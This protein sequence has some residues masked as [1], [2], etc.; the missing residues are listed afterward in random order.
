MSISISGTQSTYTIRKTSGETFTSS[1]TMYLKAG[2]YEEYGADHATKPVTGGVTKTITFTEDFEQY[3]IYTYPKLIYARYISEGGYW[4]WV[5]PIKIIPELPQSNETDY[6]TDRY[7]TTT[8][9]SYQETRLRLQVSIDGVDAL[10]MVTKDVSGR[11][12]P[13]FQSAGT[14]AIKLDSSSS[15]ATNAAQ[16]NVV[17]NYGA[18]MRF[19]VNLDDYPVSSY[20]RKFYARYETDDGGWAWAGPITVSRITTEEPGGSITSPA[21]RLKG[22]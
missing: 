19:N 12:K 9:D 13:T 11:E 10:F 3:P 7:T 21:P 1:G 4:S 15:S 6:K 17:E 16:Q 5:G 22:T 8:S 2:T 20:P 14:M 18:S